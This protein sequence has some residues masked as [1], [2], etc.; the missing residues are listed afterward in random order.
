MIAVREQDRPEGRTSV[1]DHWT[2][3][4]TCEAPLAM[5]RR[6][7]YRWV[8]LTTTVR[9]SLPPFCAFPFQSKSLLLALTIAARKWWDERFRRLK[10]ARANEVTAIS[11]DA[12]A[13][14]GFCYALSL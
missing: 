6:N 12:C 14:Y 10:R 2:P 11:T 8:G 5:P 1:R 9:S 13:G 7:G 3:P 4:S